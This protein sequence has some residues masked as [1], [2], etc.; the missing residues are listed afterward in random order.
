MQKRNSIVADNMATQEEEAY[1]EKY[2]ESNEKESAASGGSMDESV[3]LYLKEIGRTPLLSKEEGQELGRRIKEG[4][5]DAMDKLV[6]ANLRLVVSIAKKYSG[7]GMQL[8]DLIQEGNIGL[9]VAAKK[10]D[11]DFNTKFS[12]YATWWIRQRISRMLATSDGVIRMPAHMAETVGKINRS[13]QVF[14]QKTGVE[15][16]EEELAQSTGLSVEKIK[17]IEEMTPRIESID[18]PIGEDG[19]TTLSELIDSEGP[20]P[21]DEA[22][23]TFRREAIDKA[24]EGLTDRENNIIKLRFGLDGRKVMTLEEIGSEYGLTRERVRQIEEKALRKLRSPGRSKHL[25][26]YA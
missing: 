24:M 15:P 18:K 13:K 6:K 10:F 9:M 19:D 1:T 20:S 11:C 22:M 26:D 8:L 23:E 25:R 4:D 3:S 5:K 12:T 21:E 14:I 7:R 16:T 17:K 2:L